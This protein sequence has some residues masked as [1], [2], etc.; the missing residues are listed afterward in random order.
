MFTDTRIV[1]QE[2][3]PHLTEGAHALICDVWVVPV[4]GTF[5]NDVAVCRMEKCHFYFRNLILV[6]K[7][8][9]VKC[10]LLAHLA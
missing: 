8:C 4:E 6:Q 5:I 10:P 1:W 9:T 2:D 3:L 7:R